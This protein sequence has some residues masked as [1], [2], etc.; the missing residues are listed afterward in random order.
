MRYG[1]PE[2]SSPCWCARRSVLPSKGS[3]PGTSPTRASRQGRCRFALPRLAPD[4]IALAS[5]WNSLQNR[6]HRRSRPQRAQ[7]V[8]SLRSTRGRPT[9]GLE[10]DSKGHRSGARAHGPE[11]TRGFIMRRL[12]AATVAA[13]SLVGA[14]GVTSASAHASLTK[15]SIK[16]NQI[17]LVK[18]APKVVMAFFAEPLDPAKSWINVFEGQADHG[19]VNEKT[20]SKVVGPNE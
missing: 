19:L 13:L 15:C 2:P 11:R 4:S 20:T 7:R 18:A 12:I 17:F 9:P 5:S 10:A 1:W 16:N 3:R 6:T 8:P 14:A